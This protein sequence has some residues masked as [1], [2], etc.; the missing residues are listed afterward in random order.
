M[1]LSIKGTVHCE[2]IYERI[3]YFT[4]VFMLLSVKGTFRICF[5]LLRIQCLNEGIYAVLSK[6]YRTL[7]EYLWKNKIKRKFMPL[8]TTRC[9]DENIQIYRYNFWVSET[10]L[11]IIRNK[12]FNHRIHT[13]FVAKQ[14]LLITSLVGVNKQNLAKYL[15]EYT[16]LSLQ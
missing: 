11:L 7:R 5:C 16:C 3:E 6:K 12:A 13:S 1:L 2:G 14:K 15:Y 10:V 9:L 8:W 4:R